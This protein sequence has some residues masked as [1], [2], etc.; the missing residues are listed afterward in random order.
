MITL[1]KLKIY[2]H[3]RGDGD[4]W[5]RMNRNS[6]A[7]AGKDWQ[8]IDSL[9]QDLFIVQNGLASKKFTENLNTRL[10]ENSDNESTIVYLKSLADS[11]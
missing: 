2:K 1:D 10:L 8:L 5:V 9:I 4:A 11:V 3:Y 7:I 6:E